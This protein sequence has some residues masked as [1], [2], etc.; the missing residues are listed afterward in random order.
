MNKTLR[1]TTGKK[2]VPI[3]NKWCPPIML[4]A[5]FENPEATGLAVSNVIRLSTSARGHGLRYGLPRSKRGKARGSFLW[6]GF[7][8]FCGSDVSKRTP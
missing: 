3:K 6:V 1:P 5:D 4:V 7:C 8:P 2:C